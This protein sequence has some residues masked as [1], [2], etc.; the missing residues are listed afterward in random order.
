MVK[1]KIGMYG[2]GT[3]LIERQPVMPPK[4]LEIAN[5]TWEQAAIFLLINQLIAKKLFLKLDSIFIC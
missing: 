5:K 3:S 4:S 1:D 2:T